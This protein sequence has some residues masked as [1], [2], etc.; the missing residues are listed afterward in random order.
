M[1]GELWCPVCDQMVPHDRGYLKEHAVARQRGQLVT[2]ARLCDGSNTKPPQDLKTVRFSGMCPN[3]VTTTRQEFKETFPGSLGKYGGVLVIN[4]P[5]CG[6][7]GDYC[8]NCDH[9][10]H[11]KEFTE[12]NAGDPQ[13]EAA[14]QQ[15]MTV[16][17]TDGHVATADEV[18]AY[19]EAAEALIASQEPVT[20][21][22]YVDN[23]GEPECPNGGAHEAYHRERLERP[24]M[25]TDSHVIK[26]VPEEE[27]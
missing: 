15:A 20:V 22:R 18:R 12:K 16:I 26:E 23:L 24:V 25:L 4:C 8:K 13:L 27:D 14:L 9:S 17:T 2:G 19:E 3:C 11:E 7:E 21:K 10:L 1:S 5:E 6:D